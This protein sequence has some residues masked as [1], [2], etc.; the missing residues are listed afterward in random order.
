MDAIKVALEV[1]LQEMPKDK[2]TKSTSESVSV[3]ILLQL[4]RT[5]L[6]FFSSS[7][8]IQKTSSSEKTLQTTIALRAC[9]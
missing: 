2:P 8:E 5:S 7:D 4:S 9:L 6:L 3:V 1:P